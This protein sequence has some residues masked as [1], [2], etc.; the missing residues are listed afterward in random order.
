MSDIDPRNP[1]QPPDHFSESGQTMIPRHPQITDPISSKHVCFYKSGDPQFSGLKMVINNRTFKSFDALLDTLSKKVPLPFGV[2]NITTP[3]G[4]HGINHLDELEDGKSYICSDQKKVKPI[5][6]DVASKKPV[7]WYTTRPVSARRRAVHLARQNDS[8]IMKRENSLV[9]RT[10]KKLVVFK[11][12]DSGIKHTIMLQKKTSQ[13]FESLL[14]HVTEVMQFPVVKLYTPD[15]RR[16]DSLQSLILCS[17]VVV[18]SGR[19]P[20]KPGSY[21]PQTQTL[22]AKLPGVSS[23]VQPKHRERLGR[24]NR[25][26]WRVSVVTSSLPSAG[27]SSQVYIILY[28]LQ[29]NSGPLFLLGREGD[30]FQSGHEDIFDINVGNIGELFKIRIGHNSSG[31]SPG[32]HCEEVRLQ[33]L[34]TEEMFYLPVNRWLSQEEEKGGEIC[35]EVPV[36]HHGYPVFPVTL[37]GVSVVTGDL[38]NAG[39]GA[40]VY[41][42]VY[43]ENGDTGSRQLLNSKKPTTFCKGQVDTFT[44]E[45]VHLGHLEKVVIGHDGLGEGSGWFL[46][47]VV[48]TDSL[49]DV[50]YTFLC[51]RWLDQGE[52]DGKIVTELYVSDGLNY[53]TRQELEHKRMEIWAV[54]RWKFQKGNIVQLFCKLTGKCVRLHPDGTVDALGDKRDKQGFFDMRLKRG[55]IRV[56]RS[57]PHPQLTLAIA[58]GRV[59]ALEN[60]GSLCE[61]QVQ[62]HPN[63]CVSLESVQIPGYLV[64]FDTEGH[65]ADGATGYSGLCKEFVVHVKGMLR[66]GAVIMLN[67]SVSQALCITRDGRCVGTGRQAEESYFRVHKVCPGVCMFQSLHCPD[68]YL[69]VKGGQC[70]GRGTGD[71][72]SHFKVEKNYQTGSLSLESVKCSG[73]FLGL[74]P[75]GSAKP[76]VHTGVS[77]VMFYPQVI[78]YGR[79]KPTGTSAT[80]IRHVTPV[81][82][83]PRKSPAPFKKVKT[84]RLE[85]LVSSDDEWTVSVVTGYPGTQAQVSLWIYGSEGNAGPILLEKSNRDTL[86]SPKQEDEFQLAMTNIGEIYKIRIGHDGTSDHP[87]WNLQSVSL[88]KNKDGPTLQFSVN[89]WLS[90]N[91]GNGDILCE[92]AAMKEDGQPIFPVVKYQVTIYTGHLNHAETQS[93][94]LI[95]LYGERG[96]SG[97][98]LLHK[99]Q[100]ANTFRRG[101]VDAFELEAVSLGK[102]QKVLLCC[103]AKNKSDYWYCEKVII[104]EPGGGSEYIFNCERWIPFSSEGVVKT[105]IE[106]QVQEIRMSVQHNEKEM[107]HDGGWKVTVVTGDFD[108]ASTEATVYLHAYGEKGESGPI[109][110]GSGKHQLFNQNSADTFQVDFGC[111]GGLYKLRIGH[112]NSGED[113]K[114]YLEEVILHELA[115][116]KEFALRVDQWLAGENEDGRV[117]KEVPVP[118]IGGDS[119]SVVVYQVQVHT[120]SKPGAETDASVYINIF[121]TR[122]DTGKRKLHQSLNHKL[123]FQQGQVDIFNIEAV[124]LEKLRKVVIGHNGT[125]PG[126]GWFLEK[127]IIKAEEED[128][129][130]SVFLCNSWLDVYQDDGKTERE[131]FV[132]GYEE[133]KKESQKGK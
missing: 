26:K 51:N 88:R 91:H 81:P 77:N 90:R 54:E 87:D 130:E 119:L 30:L 128:K 41:I 36:L 99:A 109:I 70:N 132:E 16:V 32:W 117:W 125:G 79:E 103:E 25:G 63:R 104:G 6:L 114:W 35:R 129:H 49:K 59:T 18:A 89:R 73:M 76:L 112:D 133:I 37:Y 9:V 64:T 84:K 58:K 71:C 50:E 101:Q 11:N 118:L 131:L 20:F 48:L 47:K 22:P 72:Y 60:G 67:S 124:S 97:L 34:F 40:N 15:G 86:F 69:Q 113:P 120:G 17:G 3:R 38:W 123:K 2:R 43:G 107:P 121:G 93:P 24:R 85:P 55:N 75:D 57:L 19:E 126:D 23:H 52:M 65:P 62:I 115:T 108:S 7:P 13:T 74:L 12:G 66:D 14:G 53:S 10:P 1:S 105:G 68:M 56:F 92:V 100:L 44:L 122:G 116:G 95:C 42:N 96:D 80:P 102:L 111:I 110:L 46:E 27:T 5:D 83:I 4:I 8:R 39:T 31:Q 33:N 45:A 94:V 21:D 106:L 61:L 98:R 82:P 28:G 29:G 78:Q 127:V